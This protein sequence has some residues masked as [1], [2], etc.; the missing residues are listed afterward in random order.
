M[1]L[2][3][4][5]S[6]VG[7]GSRNDVKKLIKAGK[8]RVNDNMVKALDTKINETT[9][10]VYLDDEILEFRE[11]RYYI[12]NKPAGVLSALHDKND[13]TVMDILPDFV[14]TKNLIIAGRLDKDT[15][16]LLLLTTDGKF[17]HQL[18]SPKNHIPKTY[19]VRLE[20]PVNEQDIARLEK[21][22]VISDNGEKYKTKPAIAKII[23]EN[24][25]EL[26]ITEGKFHQIKKMAHAID[27]EV[28]FLKRTAFGKLTIG[29]MQTGE[30]REISKDEI[31]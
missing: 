27:N 8:I 10:K 13:T 30:V 5:L 9:D 24:E 20:N 4:F 26:T 17:S 7:I 25:I 3:K 12:I 11:F 31:L 23:S 6:D 19:F 15:E 1:R 21:G 2:D 29:E 22:V 14:I 28:I 16:G 18:L